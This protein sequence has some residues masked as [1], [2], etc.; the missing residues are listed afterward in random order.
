[1]PRRKRRGH[2]R[3]HADRCSEVETNRTEH[4][5]TRRKKADRRLH[6]LQL[7]LQV[8]WVAQRSCF[9]ISMSGASALCVVFSSKFSPGTTQARTLIDGLGFWLQKWIT[10]N[11]ERPNDNLGLYRGVYVLLIISW[12]SLET[13]IGAVSHVRSFA[14]ETPSEVSGQKGHIPGKEWPQAGAISF[15]NVSASYQ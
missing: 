1:M 8:R 15:E 9:S 10:T 12:T 11:S 13:S 7:L 6:G 3:T 14:R 5:A 4:S 2:Y